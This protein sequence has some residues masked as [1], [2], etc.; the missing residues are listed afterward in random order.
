MLKPQNRKNIMATIYISNSIKNATSLSE[1]VG[2]INGAADGH[3]E[4][5]EGLEFTPAMLAGQ[6]AQA[7]AGESGYGSDAECIEAHLD[8]LENEGAKFDCHAAMKHGAAI[9]DAKAAKDE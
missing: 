9:A 3:V 7:A 5:M 4:G 1:V 6:Y 2:I 8:I